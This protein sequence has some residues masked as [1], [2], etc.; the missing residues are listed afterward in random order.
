MKYLKIDRGRYYYQRRVPDQF[1]DLLGISKWQMPCGD[2]SYAKAVQLIVNWAEEH[3]ELLAKLKTSEGY[4]AIEA[5]LLRSE[6]AADK[7]VEELNDGIRVFQNGGDWAPLDELAK[8][9]MN[10][11]EEVAKLDEYH[12]KAKAPEHEVLQLRAQIDHSKRG[13]PK[14]GKIKLS[15]YPEFI[16]LAQVHASDAHL[17]EFEFTPH[18]PRPMSD[19]RYHDELNSIFQQYF[20]PSPTPP[21]DPDDRDEYMFAKHRI[22]R[23]I[24]SVTPDK[25]SITAVLEKY[26]KFNSIRSGTRSKYRRE[27]ARLTAITGD[28]PLGH[29]RTEDLKQLRDG[30]IG[31]IQVASIQAIFTPIKGIFAFAFDEDIIPVNPMLGVKLPKD[32]R[33]I[34]ERKWK[35]FT[36]TEVIRILNAAEELWSTP[37]QGLSDARREAIH[38]VVRVLTYSGMRP[39]EVIRLEPDDVTDS[40]IRITGSKTES[41]TRF[42]PLHPEIADFPAWVA[43]GGLETFQSIKTDQ[44]GSVRHNFSRLLRKKMQNPITDPQKA[45]YSL[46]STFVN[47]MRRA[48]ADIQVQRAILG[49]K[50]AGAI[51]HYDDGPEFEVKRKWVEATDPKR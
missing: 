30:L 43:S 23:K 39:V 26:C 33:P 46:R 2:V 25:N 4:D 8:P 41:S 20:G 15:P 42:V 24:S 38:M 50:E 10:A 22:E 48:G 13:G 14:L 29:V 51:R 19:E 27:I 49:H 34:E 17:V 16:E 11:L 32:K 6:D 28:V 36:P 3:D 12:S 31:T 21:S 37:V 9:W 45:L 44:V 7:F 1:R 47:A 40:W 5:E 18:P 35:S